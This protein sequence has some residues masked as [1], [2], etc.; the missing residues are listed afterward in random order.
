MFLKGNQ[1]Y[2][3]LSFDRCRGVLYSMRKKLYKGFC[4]SGVLRCIE[5]L[6]LPIIQRFV[7][8]ITAFIN[9]QWM[10][11]DT[12]FVVKTELRR[13][14][15]FNSKLRCG[16]NHQQ[17]NTEHTC[18]HP[19]MCTYTC[20]Q[21]GIPSRDLSWIKLSGNVRR[22]QKHSYLAWTLKLWP[23][24]DRSKSAEHG[25]SKDSLIMLKQ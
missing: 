17:N 19:V 4:G 23:R 5:S 22:W 20:I 14:G 11:Q 16:C 2:T 3:S 21:R 18:L 15:H 13:C 9:P 1:F 25:F 12:H 24:F 6:H 10:F 7:Q 8:R